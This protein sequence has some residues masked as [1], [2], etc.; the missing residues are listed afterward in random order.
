[1]AG[2]ILKQK[3]IAAGLALLRIIT[4]LLMAFHGLEIFSKETMDMYKGWDSV[5]SLPAGNLFIYVGKAVELVAGI[6]LTLGLFTRWAA[7]SMALIMLFIC[8]YIGNGKFWYEDQHPF[9]FAML[10]LV[11]AIY[12]P[13]A[14][15]FDNKIK[16]K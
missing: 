6:F 12:G 2:E 16:K 11:F 15:A 14:W 10:A 4:G 9:L 3:R 13:G 7:L 5:K 1:M 8:F